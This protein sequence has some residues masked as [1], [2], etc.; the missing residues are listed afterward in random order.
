MAK[1]RILIK[2]GRIID[3]DGDFDQIG[4]ILIE[5]GLIS[6]RGD[7]Q[8]SSADTV[9]EAKGKIVMP[10]MVDMHVHLREPGRE[11]KETIAS[12]TTAALRGGVTS[13]LAMPNTNP[14]IDSPEHIE[15]LSQI[16]KK[17]A[18]IE[19]LICGTITKKRE[20]LEL[21]DI[22]ALK[23]KGALAI[24]DD[25]SSV[26]DLELMRKAFQEAKKCGLLVICHSEDKKLSGDGAVNLGFTSTRLGLKGISKE[27]E[28]KRVARDVELAK[29]T[30]ARIHIA[31]VSCKE[32]IEIIARAKQQKIAVSAET[33]PHYFTLC[34]Q[35]VL[36]FDTNMKMN[37]P[38][39]GKED[40]E[41]IKEGL[42]QGIIDAIASDHAP[43]ASSEK[44]IEFDRAAFGV[45]GLETELA[46]AI[47][48]LVEPGILSWLQ[49]AKAVSYNPAKILG[50]D[51]G[52]LSVGS[53]A[54]IVVI[55]PDQEWVV[56]KEAFLSKSK[57]SC[58][59]EKKLKGQVIYTIHQG[60]VKWSL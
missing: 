27:S 2:G 26:D 21:S 18:R 7:A 52:K 17:T 34:D 31:H 6:H 48:E 35:A 49:L 23:K 37:P 22:T 43:H 14:A 40:L 46:V 16:I 19:V 47:T 28:Y 42:R 60:Q 29:E 50:I 12:G 38:L 15:L 55:S 36:G 4:D 41:A 32:S 9:I 3:P 13:V 25:G 59:L 54:E 44:D 20:G 57:N 24:T 10:A 53:P 56:R 45:I 11:D 51:K 58:F 39:R 30:G 33:A 5:D 1:K 8:G